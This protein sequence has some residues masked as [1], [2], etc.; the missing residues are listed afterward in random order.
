MLAW[1][2]ECPPGEQYD[3]DKVGLTNKCAQWFSLAL[4]HGTKE[5]GVIKEA[6]PGAVDPLGEPLVPVKTVDSQNWKTEHII[7]PSEYP[8][9]GYVDIVQEWGKTYTG[10]MQHFGALTNAQGTMGYK[11]NLT[12]ITSDIDAHDD[13]GKA[14]VPV[15]NGQE[16]GQIVNHVMVPGKGMFAAS[17]WHAMT[18]TAH[19]SDRPT[20]TLSFTMVGL[21]FGAFYNHI[22]IQNGL[23][24]LSISLA[25][26][27]TKVSVSLGTSPP[28]LPKLDKL[29]PRVEA[30]V[31]SNAFG[32]TY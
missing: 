15:A 32:R 2:C 1:L 12:N 18:N 20:E 4:N 7:L 11:I 25:E 30:R 22:G 13:A 16:S 9:A 17:A 3:P 24:S 26:D 10:I 5:D 28:E 23:R 29:L 14:G 6:L 8:Y 21:D 19:S 31:N 27:G